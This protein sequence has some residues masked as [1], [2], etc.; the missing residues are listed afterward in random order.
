[1]CFTDQDW[2]CEGTFLSNKVNFLS[3]LKVSVIRLFTPRKPETVMD[4]TQLPVQPE[5][6]SHH[7]FYTE[8]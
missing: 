3:N 6:I 4:E 8:N 7:S 1:M 2:R 5:S